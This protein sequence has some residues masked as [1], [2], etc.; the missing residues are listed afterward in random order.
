MTNSLGSQTLEFVHMG[1]DASL[2][3]SLQGM[4][5]WKQLL[6]PLKKLREKATINN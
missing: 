3:A 6:K 5:V 1:T 4:L 2:Q